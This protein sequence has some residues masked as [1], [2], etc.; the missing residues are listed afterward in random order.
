MYTWHFIILPTLFSIYWL[1]HNLNYFIFQTVQ[2]V[3][4]ASLGL[5]PLSESNSAQNAAKGSKRH[6]PL[7]V[8]GLSATPPK[9]TKINSLSPARH[10]YI[11]GKSLKK[12]SSPFILF[13]RDIRRQGL[14]FSI[15]CKIQ[16]K[17]RGIL[18][19]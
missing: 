16:I 2:L 14:K 12:P 5:K 4:A 15:C 18:L 10:D 19:P 1:V 17:L 3:N 8:G 13:S 11:N 9:K 6:V 7:E